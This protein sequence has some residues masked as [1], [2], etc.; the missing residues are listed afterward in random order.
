M[1]ARST[2]LMGAQWDFRVSALVGDFLG[3]DKSTN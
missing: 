3:L 2:G 1:S